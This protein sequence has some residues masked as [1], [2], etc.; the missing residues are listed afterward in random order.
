MSLFW[1]EKQYYLL[2]FLLSFLIS[3]I[4]S[5]IIT[6]KMIANSSPFFKS[7]PTAS[8]SQPIKVGPDVQPI[9]PATARNANIAVEILGIA[10]VL[11]LIV[12]GHIA[13]TDNPHSAQPTSEIIAFG[14]RQASRY[15][16]MHRDADA[17]RYFSV[18]ILL[19]SLLKIIRPA[20][21]RTANAIGPARSPIVFETP[22]AVSAKVDAH[23]LIASSAAPEQII[24]TIA[25]MKILF[26]NSEPDFLSAGSSLGSIIGTRQKNIPLKIANTAHTIVSMRQFS[27]PKAAKKIVDNAITPTVPQQ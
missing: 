25:I 14:D 4:A 10:L 12:P 19:L 11:R 17:I 27:L 3:S 22:S 8:V 7:P 26:L 20:P 13:D 23:W 5:I 21:I 15:E 9:S 6:G 18:F 1:S 16:M 2:S 24:R